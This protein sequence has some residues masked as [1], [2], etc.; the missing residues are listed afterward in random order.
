M[1]VG[2]SY[3]DRNWYKTLTRVPTVIIQLDE[4]AL[5]GAGMSL[6]WVPK[7]PRAAPIY[8]YKGKGYSLMNVMDSK[9]GG[10]MTAR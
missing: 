3:A 8:A 2:G 7:D 4:K 10:E 6:L 9:V 1:V 5:V